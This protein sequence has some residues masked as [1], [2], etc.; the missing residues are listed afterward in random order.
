MCLFKSYTDV[1]DTWQLDLDINFSTFIFVLKFVSEY[2]FWS[3]SPNAFKV[4]NFIHTDK[5]NLVYMFPIKKQQIRVEQRT[6]GSMQNF[7][8]QMTKIEK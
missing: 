5:M 4:F 1:S 8:K 3:K 2:L 7:Y 6:G